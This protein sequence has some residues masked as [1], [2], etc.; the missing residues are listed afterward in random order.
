MYWGATPPATHRLT[1]QENNMKKYSKDDFKSMIDDFLADHADEY[2]DDPLKIEEPEQDDDG[3][4]SC[5]AEDS[6]TRYALSDDGIG[7]IQIDYIGTK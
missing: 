4:W 7:N 6:K 5:A 2:E 3:C 1:S